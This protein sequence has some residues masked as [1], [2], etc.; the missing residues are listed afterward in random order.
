MLKF[1]FLVWLV[2]NE[3]ALPPSEPST[4]AEPLAKRLRGKTPDPR[5]PPLGWSRNGSRE[6]HQVWYSRVQAFLDGPQKQSQGFYVKKWRNM[7][8]S[9]R[10][11]WRN[12]I[13][14]RAGG[15]AAEDVLQPA[16]SPAPA[17]DPT[18]PNPNSAQ[19][20][21]GSSALQSERQ[22][23]HVRE[24]LAKYKD[25]STQAADGRYRMQRSCRVDHRGRLQEHSCR[26]GVPTSGLL[27]HKP[28]QAGNCPRPAS[29]RRW[30][31]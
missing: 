1:Q 28:S 3:A 31:A 25:V 6:S 5:A 7:D 30:C 27:T 19:A 14:Q 22:D 12:D 15:V 20:S 16:G 11:A 29:P 9:S 13:R 17:P 18:L 23:D 10:N 21:P 2:A 8:E 24:L 4:P 26:A